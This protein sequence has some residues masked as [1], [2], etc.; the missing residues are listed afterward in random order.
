MARSSTTW[1]KGQ[2]GN[3]QGRPEGTRETLSEALRLV[4]EQEGMR[5]SV[6]KH[7]WSIAC[8]GYFMYG[9]KKYEVKISEWMRVVMFIFDRLDGKVREHVSVDQPLP[10][11]CLEDYQE[12][13]ARAD[14]ELREWEA[15]RAKEMAE[16]R[17]G[18]PVKEEKASKL[19]TSL[20]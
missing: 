6:A 4:G 9:D 15:K 18:P 1:Q 2:S 8:E 14:E 10:E 20:L 3:P 7:L 17:R 19:T 16:A 13:I 12:I 11:L 5:E